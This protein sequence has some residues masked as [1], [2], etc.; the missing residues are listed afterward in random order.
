[1]YVEGSGFFTFDDEDKTP[2]RVPN[3]YG[4]PSWPTPSWIGPVFEFRLRELHY[5]YTMD[6]INH[7]IKRTMRKLCPKK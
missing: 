6:E 5:H 7:I 2:V 1:M 4:T 3:P